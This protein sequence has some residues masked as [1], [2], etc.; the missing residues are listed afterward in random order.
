MSA[1]QRKPFE[2]LPSTVVPSNYTLYLHPDLVKNSF[3]G[4]ETIDVEVYYSYLLLF[5]KTVYKIV[6]YFSHLIC[7][8][9]RLI[10][11]TIPG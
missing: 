6:Q 5:I 7:Y 10:S 4:K 2:H 1:S 8:Y 11:F 9:S 3:S